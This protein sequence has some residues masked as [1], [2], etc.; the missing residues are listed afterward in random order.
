[1][2]TSRGAIHFANARLLDRVAEPPSRLRDV[3][4]IQER[5]SKFPLKS[6]D[7]DSSDWRFFRAASQQFLSI[8]GISSFLFF[9]DLFAV[10]VLAF[11]ILTFVIKRDVE[12]DQLQI[13]EDE[14]QRIL[15]LELMFVPPLE[16]EDITHFIQR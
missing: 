9:F 8:M 12:D 4:I 13:M 15:E 6:S 16:M 14:L 7:R 10:P 2:T 5:S 3:T 11:F 1:M